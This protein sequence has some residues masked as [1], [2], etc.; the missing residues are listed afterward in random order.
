MVT[1]VKAKLKNLRI[2]PRKTRLVA[3][4]IRGLPVNE[5]EAQ[6]LMSPKRAAQALLKLLRSAIFN[7]KNNH[8]L[9]EQKLFIKEIRVDEGPR[10]KRWMPRA[11]GSVSL[12]QKKS[13]HVTLVLGLN[14]KIKEQKFVIKR[15][16]KKEKLKKEQKEKEKKT[17]KDKEELKEK[18]SEKELKEKMK[19]EEKETSVVSKKGQGAGLRKIFR[20]KSI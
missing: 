3:D 4:L 8:K 1:E 12:I 9:D 20:R 10:L 14:E 7:A 6:L 5:A 11:R 2:A 19:L 18:T 15:E 13:S 17:K 16:S